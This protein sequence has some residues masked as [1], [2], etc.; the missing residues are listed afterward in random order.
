MNSSTLHE[1]LDRVR[2]LDGIECADQC[3]NEIRNAN[4]DLNDTN[5]LIRIWE[6]VYLAIQKRAWSASEEVEFTSYPD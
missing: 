2:D 6:E 5:S 1:F 4:L 3:H